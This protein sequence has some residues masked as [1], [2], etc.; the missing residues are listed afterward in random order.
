MCSTTLVSQAN[1]WPEQKGTSPLEV[2]EVTHLNQAIG[3]NQAND[4]T[5]VAG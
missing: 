5:G 1:D 2:M 3:D 4:L